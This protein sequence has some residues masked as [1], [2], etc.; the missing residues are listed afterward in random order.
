MERERDNIT[1]W[2]H[3]GSSVVLAWQF[4][5]DFFARQRLIDEETR[6]EPDSAHQYVATRPEEY[7]KFVR[8]LAPKWVVAIHSQATPGSLN[9]NETNWGRYERQQP[10]NTKVHLFT[11]TGH[12][13]HVHALPSWREGPNGWADGSGVPG[14]IDKE[15]VRALLERQDINVLQLL[16]SWVPGLPEQIPVGMTLD[17]DPELVWRAR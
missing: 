14:M 6:L 16:L 17:V 10:D 12:Q 3:G 15:V 11:K 13:G 9:D 5:L 1:S 2:S 8:N 4:F 7:S